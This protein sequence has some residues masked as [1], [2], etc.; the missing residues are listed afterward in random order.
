[1]SLVVVF[2]T[3]L[4]YDE[5]T[6][7]KYGLRLLEGGSTFD[8]SLYDRPVMALNALASRIADGPRWTTIFSRFP[9]V[10][11][12]LLL[13]YLLACWSGDLYGESA[14]RFTLFLY[15]FS[16]NILAHSTLGTSDLYA[17]LGVTGALYSLYRFLAVPTLK[18]ALIAAVVL[19]VAQ[20]TK[21]LAFYLFVFVAILIPILIATDYLRGQRRKQE[22]KLLAMYPVVAGGLFLLLLQIVFAFQGSA[23]VTR[24]SEMSFRPGI[25]QTL[26]KGPIDTLPLPRGFVEGIYRLTVD[27]SSGRTYGNLYLLGERRTNVPSGVRPF[28]SY[29]LVVYL[30]KQPIALQILLLLGLFQIARNR[31]GWDFLRREACLI[32]PMFGYAAAASFLQHAQIGIRHILPSLALATVIAGAW[33]VKK[34]VTWALSGYLVLSV[35]SYFPHMIP[36]TN[37]LIL[38]KSQVFRYFADSNLSWG[39]SDQLVSDYLAKNPSVKLNPTSFQT[40]KILAEANRLVGIPGPPDC[41]WLLQYRPIGHVGYSHMIYEIPSSH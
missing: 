24:L 3:S 19:A 9:T 25:F 12:S 20:M 1:M 38:D 16:P 23:P 33:S 11:A 26:Q 8:L 18:R 31:I 17:A 28:K 2:Q 36:Y 6:H 22:W 7:L 34:K 30:F 4:T 35:A 41:R 15:A 40:G 27:D 14:K 32:V 10:L 37:E 13:G 21:F 29:Y 39:Q 5:P